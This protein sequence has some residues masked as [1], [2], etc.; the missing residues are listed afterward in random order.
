MPIGRY[1]AWVGASLLVLLLV[2][3]WLLPQPLAEPT[4][5]E[6]NRPVIRIASMQQ[7]PERIVIDTSLPTIVPPP[8]LAADSI[9]NEQPPQVQA[10]ASIDPHTTVTG[11]EKTK[12][13]AKKKQVNHPPSASPAIVVASNS[14]ATIAPSTNLSFASIISGQLVRDLFNLR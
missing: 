8:T 14:P 3:N 7:P 9:S 6:T 12:S 5:V 4:V 10:Y 13:K 2:A 11:A 1:I